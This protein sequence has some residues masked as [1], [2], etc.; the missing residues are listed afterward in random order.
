MPRARPGCQDVKKPALCEQFHHTHPDPTYTRWKV[1]WQLQ[2]TTP[3]RSTPNNQLH[4][5]TTPKKKKKKKRGTVRNHKRKVERERVKEGR[6]GGWQQDLSMLGLP[7]PRSQIASSDTM[8][9][10]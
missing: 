10:K 7:I 9:L 6:G 5:T 8:D 1:V 4:H 3:H 2:A